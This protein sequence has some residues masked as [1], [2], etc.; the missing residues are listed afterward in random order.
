ME[1]MIRGCMPDHLDTVLSNLDQY[2]VATEHLTDYIFN[3]S[4]RRFAGHH[5]TVTDYSIQY[6]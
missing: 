2:L 3:V 5:L 1:L 4:W 6:W